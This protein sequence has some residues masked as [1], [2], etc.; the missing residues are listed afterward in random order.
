VSGRIDAR[1]CW[2]ASLLLSAGICFATEP[3]AAPGLTNNVPPPPETLWFEVGEE[4]I[5]DIFWGFIKVGHSH[6]TTEW[7]DHDDGRRLIRIRFES[8]SNSVIATI[9]P[10]EDTQEVLI[11]PST[12]LPVMYSKQ[13]RQG[14]K[15]YHEVT[16]FDHQAGVAFW[17]SLLKGTKIEVPI[18]GD[19]RDLVSLMY[20]IRTMDHEPGSQ[21]QTRV[22]TEEKI[23]D[24]FVKIVRKEKVDL[25]RYGDV[26]SMLFEPE[27]AFDGLFV[28]KGKILMWV[29]D[30]DRK[31]CTKITARVPVANISFELAEVRG[32]GQDF[33]V[34]RKKPGAVTDMPVRAR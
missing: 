25:D 24:L 17:E 26:G 7:V 10:V 8:R 29:S 19:T 20:L 22:F 2:L 30:D 11:D 23:Y 9:Y 4:V 16:R 32:P 21:I 5:Y 12:F 28:R 13:S 6:V 18:A 1:L 34:G 3:E 31:L 15:Q 27:A 14:S 33:W